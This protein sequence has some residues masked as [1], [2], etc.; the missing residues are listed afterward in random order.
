VCRIEGVYQGQVQSH[1]AFGEGSER[2]NV[3]HVLF[4]A[5]KSSQCH[6]CEYN[7]DDIIKYAIEHVDGTKVVECPMDHEHLHVISKEILENAPNRAT[8][9]PS[10]AER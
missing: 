6:P 7:D 5:T 3:F 4:L 9:P 2:N 10:I 1:H 8:S